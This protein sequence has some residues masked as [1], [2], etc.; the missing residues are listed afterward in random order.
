MYTLAQ[1]AN[2]LDSEFLLLASD[3][4]YEARALQVLQAAG[5]GSTMLVSGFTGAGDDVFV[6]ASASGGLVA[7]SKLRR[8]LSAP[9]IGEIPACRPVSRSSM[10]L[11]S[12]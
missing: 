2:R 9:V 5:A 4:A 6:E 1:L 8:E 3:P 10:R 7:L 11:A 12:H